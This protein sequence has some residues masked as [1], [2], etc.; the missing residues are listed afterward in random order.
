MT[1]A[2]SDSMGYGRIDLLRSSGQTGRTIDT[3]GHYHITSEAP[4]MSKA[5][6]RKFKPWELTWEHIFDVSWNP[7]LFFFQIQGAAQVHATE[8]SGWLVVLAGFDYTG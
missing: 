1:D 7:P 5:M 3:L 2:S 6:P 8:L 4:G